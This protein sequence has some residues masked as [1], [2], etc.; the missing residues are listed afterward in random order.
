[1][2]KRRKASKGGEKVSSAMRVA[3]KATPQMHATSTA[4]A[5]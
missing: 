5:T 4:R 2:T 1:M 3:T